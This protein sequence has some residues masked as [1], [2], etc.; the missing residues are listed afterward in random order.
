MGRYL[1]HCD[2]G[3]R[4]RILLEMVPLGPKQVNPRTPK[5]V[6]RRLEPTKVDDLIQ[7]YVDGVP[8]KELTARFQID[9]STVHK[10]VRQRGPSRRSP[11][12]GPKQS[13]EAVRLYVAGQ[14]LAKLSKHFGVA[15][16][17]VAR[18]LRSAGITLRPRRGWNQRQRGS[19]EEG[20]VSVGPPCV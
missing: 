9:P 19:S 11:R 14:S 12:L 2:Q 6:F 13:E 15:G 18:A 7:G 1:N 10:Y 4:L 3:E 20:G 17:T 5:R 8:I 16:D